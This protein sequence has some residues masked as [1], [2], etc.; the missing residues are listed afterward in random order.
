MFSFKGAGEP[1]TGRPGARRPEL[2]TVEELGKE[3]RVLRERLSRLS[4]ASLRISESLDVDTVLREVA[5]SARALTDA[6][7]A[8]IVMIDDSADVQDIVT[9]GLSPEERRALLEI[10]HGPLLW[11]YLRDV[12]RPLRVENLKTHLTSLGF[13]ADPSLSKSFLGMSIRSRGEQ[14]GD[15]YLGEKKEG[16]EFTVEDEEVLA[17]FALQAGAAISNARNHGE[18]QAARANLEA[19]IN[20]SP[21]A[22]VMFDA[23]SGQVVSMNRESMRIVE[24]LCMPGQAP[25]DLLGVV[26]V[27]RADGRELALDRTPLKEVLPEA[28]SVR[29][30]E[31]VLEVPDGRKITVLVNSTPILTE[32]GGVASVVVTMQ[33][34]TSLEE[35]EVHRAEFLGMVSHELR[36]P[37]TSIK[38]SATA[39]LEASSNLRPA[40]TLQFFR[41]IN[42]QADHMRELIGNLLDAAHI[43]AGRLSVV[44][45]PAGLPSIVDQARNL[46]LS[47][48]GT[49]PVEID[50]PPDLPRVMA[51][52]QRVVQI[53]GNLLSNAGRHSPQSSPIRVEAKRDGA[54][55]AVS[56]ADEGPGIPAERLPHL[57]RKLSRGSRGSQGPAGGTGLGLAICKGLVEAHGGGIRAES[58]GDGGGARFTFTIP[59]VENDPAAA[60]TS[61]AEVPDRLPLSVTGTPHILAVDDDPKT[62]ID[63]RRILENAGYQPIVTGDPEE[64][65]HLLETHRPDLVLLD[66]LLPGLDGIELMRAVPA[67]SE[68]PVIFLSGYGR[69]ETIARAFQFGAVDYVVK[70]FSPT[71]LV[72]RIEAALRK[73]TEP[74]GPY[75][76]G[77]L[78]IHYGQRRV[79]LDDQPVQLTATEYD[80][81]AALAT[82]AGRVSTYDY[83]LRRV[84]RSRRAGNTPIIRVFVRKLREKL[85]DDAKNPTYIFTE[86]RV[87]YRLAKCEDEAPSAG[88]VDSTL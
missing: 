83:L 49:N 54:Q 50:L 84:W 12:P 41:I 70:P 76:K 9:S 61:P 4:E 52:R 85:G 31:I 51:D 53:L 16:R 68:R 74:S 26:K 57:F 46:Y 15:F 14:V 82:N 27:R 33:D 73:D 64:V 42:E 28:K 66:L 7:S 75:R 43:E 37:L 77:K 17:L 32:E 8:V 30:E 45:E 23:Q 39:A 58:D 78:A 19:L 6:G 10:P 80:L 67:L 3:V 24:D 18:E 13:P 36:T 65:P 86:P 69:D 87:G 62:L 25:E 20:T 1:R 38:G 81:L 71:E 44:P 21:V 72:A 22:M 2:S 40:E 34:L 60:A 47:G 88:A 59:V 29:V 63:V 79:T 48:G 56:V 5:E 11:E 35:F 55:V